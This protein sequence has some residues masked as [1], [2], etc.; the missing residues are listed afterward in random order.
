[1]IKDFPRQLFDRQWFNDTVP[2]LKAAFDEFTPRS[3]YLSDKK[4]IE[5]INRLAL[6]D[7]EQPNI[8]SY[9]TRFCPNKTPGIESFDVIFKNNPGYALMKE[10]FNAVEN[11]VSQYIKSAHTTFLTFATDVTGA[12]LGVKH[13]H[14]LMN[15]DRCNVWSF[16]IPLYID[17]NHMDKNPQ[18]WITS[19]EDIFPARWYLDYDRI[20][21][22]NYNYGNF[23]VPL[24][25]K[26]FSLRFDGSRAPHYIDYKPH[27]FVWFVF[28]GVEYHDNANR[29]NGIQC[30]TELL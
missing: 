24:D 22:K 13:L 6:N 8:V 26:I 23:T 28:D 2:E 17:N 19:Q 14:P 30:I 1:M 7:T 11:Y 18:F 4:N 10:K 27:V 3:A 16:C 5:R 15:G 9:Q 20:K 25:D 12:T 21:S 29:P